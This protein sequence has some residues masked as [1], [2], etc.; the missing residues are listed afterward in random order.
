MLVNRPPNGIRAF[1]ATNLMR[2]ELRLD[3]MAKT[4]SC[5]RTPMATCTRRRRPSGARSE[6]S[7]TPERFGL[8]LRYDERM[9]GVAFPF[10]EF[11]VLLY[12]RFTLEPAADE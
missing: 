12:L 4:G 5:P 8:D 3:W 6:R 7:G 10:L 1:N 2:I 11:V 9:I